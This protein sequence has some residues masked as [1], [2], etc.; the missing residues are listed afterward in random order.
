MKQ[1]IIRLFLW[2]WL[3]TLPTAILGAYVSYK[4][5]DRFHVFQV[6]Y[7]P[8]PINISLS[9]SIQYEWANVI[10]RIKTGVGKITGNQS[11]LKNIVI[12]VPEANISQL[13]SHM[14]QSGYNYI[15]ARVLYEGRL[16]K[17]KIKYRGDYLYHWGFYKKSIRIKTSKEYLFDGMRRFNLQAP[18]SNE[19]LNNYFSYKLATQLGLIA[20]RTELVRLS[21]NN[22]DQGVYI[23][24][25]QLKEETLRRSKLMP[26][27]IYR[28]E[29]VG[30]DAFIDSGITSLFET[31]AVWDKVAINNHY[32]PT[33]KKSLEKLI[34]LINQQDQMASQKELSELLDIDAWARFSVFEALAQTKHFHSNHNWRLYYDP[35]RQKLIPIVW[36]PV[37]WAKSW[38]PKGNDQAVSEI[39][40]TE[41]HQ[42]L[43]K[44]GE[45]IRARINVLQEF[46]NS[47]KDVEF[48]R[49]VT[50]SINALESELRI[51]PQLKPSSPQ[52]VQSAMQHMKKS[53]QKIFRDLKQYA[54][55]TNKKITFSY[56]K[57]TLRLNVDG[58]L[59]VKNIRLVFSDAVKTCPSVMLKYGLEEGGEKIID[60]TDSISIAGNEMTMRAGLLPDIKNIKVESSRFPN[61]LNADSV[62]YTYIINGVDN[63]NLIDAYVK[64]GNEWE[65]ANSVDKQ[66]EMMEAHSKDNKIGALFA[67]V[68]EPPNITPLIW[69]GIIELS[70]INEINR[71]LILKPGTTL[72]MGEGATLVIKNRLTARGTKQ[73]PIKILPGSK[74]HEPWGAIVLLGR[75]A[76]YSEL[77]YCEFLGGSGLK[78]DLF[79]YTAMLS[80]HDVKNVIITD[81]LFKDSKNVD[82]MVHAV[83]SDVIINRSK[84]I[85]ANSDALDIDISNAK[86]IDSKFEGSGND[87]IDL[88]TSKVI[89]SGTTLMNNGD[90]G[91]SVGEGSYLLA[92][93]NQII[94]NEIGIEAKDS[95]LALLF[96]QTFSKNKKALSAYKKNWRYGE[97]G[98][99]IL[100]KSVV[101][102]NDKSVAAKKRSRIGLFDSFIDNTD[103]N[104]RISIISI[105]NKNKTQASRKEVLPDEL[106]EQFSVENNF[107]SIPKEMMNQINNNQRGAST[108]A[109]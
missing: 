101:T 61:Q 4:A 56:E 65:R 22:K 107:D 38:L 70:G 98:T 42:A 73:K 3:V 93:D 39:I 47:S 6:R 21:I 79:E 1:I 88:M 14:P 18:K 84:F 96:N 89:I 109:R 94:G 41:L 16:I 43:F 29:L 58:N 57:G 71:P 37:G 7:N 69:S 60:V 78:G 104:K 106:F 48:M 64:R 83:Y 80:I 31:A 19:Q 68:I 26:A 35:W 95:S 20:P 24:V 49:F 66:L 30:K 91:V 59:P 17:A 52:L 97:G 75:N 46:F 53:I 50:D 108:G 92:I 13:N 45:F 87:A 102:E 2:S 51:D 10:Q 81:C 77:K 54:F 5:L 85:R 100:S 25:E 74:N 9:G 11:K 34:K 15:K 33:A 27:D 67:P 72:L 8:S 103:K 82:D 90:K 12:F 44:N 36:D 28:G 63:V 55:D 32:E 62:K 40:E 86:I 23:L 99:I 105:D 76:N